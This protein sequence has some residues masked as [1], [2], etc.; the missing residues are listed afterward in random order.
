MITWFVA[1]P[2]GADEISWSD[3]T[4][5]ADSMADL[6]NE[7]AEGAPQQQVV[8]GWHVADLATIQIEQLEVQHLQSLEAERRTAALLFWL[9]LGFAGDLILRGFE[10]RRW[11]AVRMGA[12]LR[13]QPGRGKERLGA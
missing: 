13:R 7:S 8:N 5:V 6:N 4:S 9:G 1:T 3:R 2:D 10:V 12:A 11:R